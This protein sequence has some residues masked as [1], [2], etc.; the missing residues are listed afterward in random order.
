[1]EQVDEEW[2]KKIEEKKRREEEGSGLLFCANG[3]GVKHGPL[4]SIH[5]Y[6]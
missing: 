5:Q 1:L 2:K 4:R 6:R 3:L